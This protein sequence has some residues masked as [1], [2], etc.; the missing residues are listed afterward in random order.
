M[1]D[2]LLLHEL[3]TLVACCS[4]TDCWAAIAKDLAFGLASS[5][6]VA[7]PRRY[8]FARHEAGH[9][10]RSDDQGVKLVP[11]SLRDI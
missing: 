3:T 4:Y 9:R 5:P 10:Q 8:P 1:V 11:G 2:N 6:L 7:G